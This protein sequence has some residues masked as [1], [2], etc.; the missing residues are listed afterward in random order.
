[1]GGLISILCVLSLSL[2]IYNEIVMLNSPVIKKNTTVSTDPDKHSKIK[3]N[4]DIFFPN[5]PCFLINVE[6]FTSVNHMENSEL[7]QNFKWSHVDK[8]G[9]EVKNFY[10]PDN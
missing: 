7:A 4:L 3:M 10:N 6:V 1:M 2:L 8:N 9:K 5:T